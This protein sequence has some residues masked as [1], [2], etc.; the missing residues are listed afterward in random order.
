MNLIKS[1]L[2][3]EAVM[4][5]CYVLD[6]LLILG[7]VALFLWYYIKNTKSKKTSS[8]NNLGNNAQKVDDDTYLLSNDQNQQVYEE[9]ALPKD[10]AVEHFVNQIADINEE[11][12]NELTSNAVIVNHEVEPAVKKIPKKDEIQ[13]YVVIGGKKKELSEDEK[14]TTFNRGSN[15]FKNSTNF[16]NTIKSEQLIDS[17]NNQPKAQ[18]PAEPKAQTTTST[19][20]KTTK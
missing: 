19:K 6:A 11:S 3:A 1:F 14:V 16:L 5:V 2:C 9:P 18:K 13:N 12:N 15:A 4:I 20:K 10:N 17:A 7:A 8:K